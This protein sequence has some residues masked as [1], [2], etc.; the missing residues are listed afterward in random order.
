MPN[1][2]R[3]A[4]I[5]A[6]FGAACV[7]SVCAAAPAP[8]RAGTIDDLLDLLKAKGD[9]TQAEYDKLKAREQEEAR[10]NDGKLRAAEARARAAEARAR[11]AEARTR[12]R[13][14]TAQAQSPTR[15]IQMQSS[16]QMQTGP[17][18]QGKVLTQNIPQAPSVDQP[19]GPSP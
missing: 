14:V 18:A 17:Q 7:L 12:E 2:A 16:A 10:K 13:E 5:A 4:A 11:A 1:T 19:A 3:V 6:K 9:I 8:V 15:P